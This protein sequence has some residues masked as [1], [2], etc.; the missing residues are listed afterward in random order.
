MLRGDQ[1]KALNPGVK[2][3][4]YN[5]LEKY[6][7]IDQILPNAGLILLY[8]SMKNGKRDDLLGHWVCLFRRGNTVVYFDP[9]G[10]NIDQPL[11]D[12]KVINTFQKHQQY[13]LLDLLDDSSYDLDVNKWQLQNGYL[14]SQDPVDSCG[15]WTSLRLRNKHLTNDE[16]ADKYHPS[17]G[18]DMDEII[19][20]LVLNFKK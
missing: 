19:S 9:Y 5:A 18:V 16:F 10:S 13:M 1:I 3:L 2:L 6:D 7:S 17:P 4:G 15:W 12:H 11:R 14:N 8:P 20:D